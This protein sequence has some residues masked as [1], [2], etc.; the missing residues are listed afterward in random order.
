MNFRNPD[1]CIM[2]SDLCSNLATCLSILILSA[3][4]PA[5]GSEDDRLYDFSGADAAGNWAAMTDRV[6]G[7]RSSGD[8]MVEN[9]VLRFTG[10]LSLENDGG[11]S[12]VETDDVQLNFG[13]ATGMRLRVRGDG[14]RYE[15]RLATSARH[16]G[17]RVQYSANF[18]TKAGEWV[19]VVVPFSGMT[20][21]HHGESLDGPPL[22]LADIEQ[23]GILLGDKTPGSFELEVDWLRLE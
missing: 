18:E 7:G 6:M 17:D 4:L 19:E 22:D 16:R 5:V 23:V 2:K 20:P 1:H 8:A 21:S 11:F 9:G 3:A 15:L 14:R 12:L 10:E 13:E